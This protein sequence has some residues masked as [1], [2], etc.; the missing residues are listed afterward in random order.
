MGGNPDRLDRRHRGLSRHFAD[1]AFRHPMARVTRNDVVRTFA[2]GRSRT[3]LHPLSCAQGMA[4]IW[5]GVWETR[6]S[7]PRRS[8]HAPH[9]EVSLMKRLT[10]STALVAAAAI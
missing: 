1:R 10:L 7:T 6:R 4:P 8:G 2:S 5:A 9:R 3:G